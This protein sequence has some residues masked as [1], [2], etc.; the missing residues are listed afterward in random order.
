MSQRL[1]ALD[2]VL[3]ALTEGG[4]LSTDALARELRLSRFDAR[5]VLVDA[6]AH[7]FVRTNSRGE[8][9]IS[10]LGHEA[11]RTGFEHL[12]PVARVQPDGSGIAGYLQRLRASGALTRWVAGLHPRYLARRGVPLAMGA[13]V[14]AGGVAVASSRLEGPEGPPVQVPHLKAP[15]HRRSH[16]S[17]TRSTVLPITTHTR[18]RRR[19]TLTATT[20]RAH[21]TSVRVVRQSHRRVPNQCNKRHQ[22]HGRGAGVTGA[23]AGKHRGLSRSGS[24][25]SRAAP[26]HP[27]PGVEG[28]AGTV[29]S[30][31]P[32]ASGT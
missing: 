23:C 13:I 16:A 10:D 18:T 9:A 24:G 8:W 32:T 4:P 20:P 2:D 5:L 30:W 31:P 25:G 26:R 22:M 3:R 15:T 21:H 14:C 28:S 17:V 19:S 6:H 1:V 29:A 7:G 27:H 12:G 11:L